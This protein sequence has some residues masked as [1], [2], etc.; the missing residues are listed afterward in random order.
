MKNLRALILLFTAKTISGFSQ[1]ISMIYIP[2]HFNKVIDEPVLFGQLYFA[3]TF[4]SLFWGLYVGTLVDKYSR[5]YLFMGENLVGA[6]V[7]S[8]LGW[9]M[10]YNGIH[11]ALVGLAFACTF[12]IYNI[13][14]PTLYAFAQEL[15]EKKHYGKIST[16]L[17]IQGQ[18]TT[19]GGGAFAAMLMSGLQKGPTQFLG[20]NINIPF[21]FEAWTV[22]KVF[23]LDGITYFLSFLIIGLI[24]YKSTVVRKKERGNILA[25]FKI[26]VDFLKK[27]PLIFVFGN[28]AYFIFVTVMVTNYMLMPNFVSSDLMGTGQDY[29]LSE[30]FYALGAFGAG[31]STVYLFRKTTTVL[32]NIVLTLLGTLVFIGLFFTQELAWLY[33]CLFLLAIANSG[34]R[35]MRVVYILKRVP[36]QVIGRSQSVFSVINVLFRLGFI[37]LFSMAFF[38]ENV[39]YAFGVFAASTLVAAI[40]LLI[41]RKRLVAVPEID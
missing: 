30:L 39:R 32:G 34:S 24:S 3:I 33:L 7:F 28:A 15:I 17:E 27:N 23:I 19:V 29:A 22:P 25:Q 11:T 5:K 31:L 37:F 26:G 6:L 40:V 8:C 21:G 38:A 9:Y 18:L 41:Y 12:F 4:V 16:L 20:M 35:I 10:W 1:G 13:H 36:N 2:W 14:Y